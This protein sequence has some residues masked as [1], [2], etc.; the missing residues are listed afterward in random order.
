MEHNRSLL[1]RVHVEGGGGGCAARRLDYC[2]CRCGRRDPLFRQGASPPGERTDPKLR[3]RGCATCRPEGWLRCGGATGRRWPQDYSLE[4]CQFSPVLGPVVLGSES[5]LAGMS[6]HSKLLSAD[7]QQHRSQSA[8]QH[9]CA[10][11]R[12]VADPPERRHQTTLD[13]REI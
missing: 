8:R 11:C 13:S 12:G 9:P 1:G 5:P 3:R 6:L 2:C 10:W 7:D 4:S